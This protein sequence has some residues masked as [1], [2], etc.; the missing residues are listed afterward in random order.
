[1]WKPGTDC[2]IGIRCIDTDAKSVLSKDPAKVLEN[3]E[4]E[5]KRKYL[6]ACLAQRRHFTP[7]VVSTDG[8]LGRE[9]KNLLRRLS[10]LLSS[11]WLCQCSYEHHPPSHSPL[12]TRLSHPNQPDEPSSAV[13]RHRRPQPLPPLSPA[14]VALAIPASRQASA[15]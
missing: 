6:G 2:I 8:L 15:H 5:K 7:F 12:P 3:Q 1:M 11:V 9:A 14:H 10:A 4:R 13:G